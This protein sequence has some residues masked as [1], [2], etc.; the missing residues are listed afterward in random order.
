MVNDGQKE[1]LRFSL[2]PFRWKRARFDLHSRIEVHRLGER[3]G[4]ASE[5]V[6]KWQDAAARS[7]VLPRM[8][9]QPA[10]ALLQT[11]E[12]QTTTVLH[13]VDSPPGW[14]DRGTQRLGQRG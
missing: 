8:T 7:Q 11:D 2:N 12:R 4:L 10:I 3:R 9:T 13:G 1:S 6:E 14:K 5:R